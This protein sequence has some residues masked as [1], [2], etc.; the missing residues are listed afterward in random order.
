MDLNHY[1]HW[2]LQYICLTEYLILLWIMTWHC[3]WTR[4]ASMFSSG[5]LA[6]FFLFLH[7]LAR[8]HQCWSLQ[9]KPPLTAGAAATNVPS[10]M[11]SWSFI[12]DLSI[13]L[14]NLFTYLFIFGLMNWSGGCRTSPVKK[15]KGIIS[16]RLELKY[17]DVPLSLTPFNWSCHT[18]V[19]L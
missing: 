2:Y 7:L 18:S 17:V 3:I 10:G 12:T 5:S 13:I 4:L 15:L 11:Y 8:H 19:G 9:W 14:I 16:L 6:F 1:L